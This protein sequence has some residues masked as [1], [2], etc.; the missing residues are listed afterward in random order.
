MQT[1]QAH[2]SARILSKA[3]RL[4]TNRTSQILIELLQNARRAG[5]SQITVTTSPAPNP[6]SHSSSPSRTTDPASTTSTSF[7]TWVHLGGMNP[8]SAPRIR[9]A[10]AY[11]RS[12][13]PA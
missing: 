8:S 7:S 6:G 3:G 13:T 12:C 1:I 2:V 5:A 11:S 10:W 4:F 9:R